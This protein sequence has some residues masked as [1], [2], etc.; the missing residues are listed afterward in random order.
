M[1]LI[2]SDFGQSNNDDLDVAKKTQ[3]TG[4][5]VN[6]NLAAGTGNQME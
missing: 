2:G 1:C 6:S 4:D 5:K 3:K